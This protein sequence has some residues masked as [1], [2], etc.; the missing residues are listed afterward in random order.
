MKPFRSW[1]ITAVL[2]VVAAILA[3]LEESNDSGGKG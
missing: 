1:V 2:V 3:I